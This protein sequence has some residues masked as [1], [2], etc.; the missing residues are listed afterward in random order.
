[1]LETLEDN[2]QVLQQLKHVLHKD[3]KK[4]LQEIIDDLT[5]PTG[6]SDNTDR[7]IPEP[8]QPPPSST[9]SSPTSK[10]L[11]A[12]RRSVQ[13][14]RRSTASNLNFRGS[15]LTPGRR[16]AISS[17]GSSFRGIKNR[18][19]IS[20]SATRSRIESF[21][22]TSQEQ[23]QPRQIPETRRQPPSRV[24]SEESS[25]ENESDNEGSSRRRPV[26]R[27]GSSPVRNRRHRDNGADSNSDRI[28]CIC[29]SYSYGDMIACDNNR[30]KIEW[31]HFACVDI[32]VQPKGKW[33]CPKCRG[34][35]SKVK[36]P[37][38]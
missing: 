14:A 20:P 31:F 23:R 22:R 29:K 17:R 2:L 3:N 38:A 35:S 16:G 26:S 27:N 12:A 13:Q 34:E 1:M 5:S 10:H 33:Y 37:D 11:K 36:R 28:Y 6:V 4:K 15:K 8:P 32:R 21:R 9:F 25:G 30:C 19:V 18:G 24:P 7:T